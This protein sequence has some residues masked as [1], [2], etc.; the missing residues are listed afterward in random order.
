MGRQRHTYKAN[1]LPSGQ[2]VNGR[3]YCAEETIVC[4]NNAD[5]SSEATVWLTTVIAHSLCSYIK[6]RIYS[7]PGKRLKIWWWWWLGQFILQTNF[8]RHDYDIK[9]KHFPRYWPFLRW[10]VNSQGPVT[11]SFNVLFDLSLDKRLSKQAGDLRCHRAHYDVT[12]MYW[13][14]HRCMDVKNQSQISR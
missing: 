10:P 5:S 9:W 7:F 13:I 1:F 11:R 4:D 8:A 12:V 2:W 3:T 6:I 14:K